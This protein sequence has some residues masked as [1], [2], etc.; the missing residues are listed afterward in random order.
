MKTSALEKVRAH[1]KEVQKN[2]K[3]FFSSIAFKEE[4]VYTSKKFNLEDFGLYPLNEYFEY[5]YYDDNTGIYHC[6]NAKGI[7]LE[8]EPMNGASDNNMEAI[9]GF[10]QRTL[11]EGAIMHCLLYASPHLGEVFDDYVAARK[12]SNPVTRKL[13]EKRA[14]YWKRG[15]FKSLVSWQQ[16]VLR[17]Y[18]LLICL[19]FDHELDIP[20]SK[21]INLYEQLRGLFRS[22]NVPNSLV[23]PARFM[24]WVDTL[25]RPNGSLYQPENSYHELNSLNSLSKLLAAPHHFK[26]VFSDHILIDD[27]EWQ[28]RNYRVQ[29][30][31]KESSHLCQMSG[32]IGNL[33]ESNAQIGCPFSLS[34]IVKICN[35]FEESRNANLLAWRALQRAE[36]IGKFSPKAIRDAQ[37]A[38]EIISEIEK[39]ERLV[40]V[41]FQISLYCK[42]EEAV[43]H[44]NSLFNVFQSTDFKWQIIKNFMLQPVMMLSH[45]PL[46]QNFQW[47]K[48]MEKLG[49][50]Y[51]LW[52]KNAAGMMPMVAEPKGMSS[53]KFMLSGRRGQVLFFDPF[54]SPRGNYNTCVAGV[55]GAGKS[56]TVQDMVGSLVGTGGKVF[57]ID[58]GRS[59]K[60]LC[61]ELDGQF[62]EF[63]YDTPICLNP[64]SS[65]REEKDSEEEFKAFMVPL[66]S[67]MI[68]P[69]DDLLPIEISF[70]SKAVNEVLKQ[71][72]RNGEIDDIIHWLLIQEDSRAQDIGQ[73]LFPFS[74]EG[75]YGKYFN[76]VGN[77]DFS[78]PM[79]VFE[80]EEISG[81]KRFQS[82]IFALLM[83]QIT[84][85][86]YLGG[87]KTQ[88]SLFIDEAWDMLKGG[89]GAGIIESV[90]R[91]ARKYKGS[92]NAITQGLEDFFASPAARAAYNNSYWKIMHM[93]N[94]ENVETLVEAKQLALNPFEKRLLCSVKTEHGVY[95][96]LVIKGGGQ[97]YICG[98]LF[99]DPYSR[100]LYSTQA[101]DFERVNEL[102]SQ[103]L[104]L[105]DA[106]EARAKE[107]FPNEI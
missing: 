80:L 36:S 69:N 57:I 53:K 48:D 90:A 41:S 98:R 91:R 42:T 76:G 35:V 21:I 55:S 73:M 2:L 38:R 39:S 24:Q 64:F 102:C 58:V 56:V 59:Y 78:N 85:K 31:G 52:A 104:S 63:N 34:F 10:L 28:I 8:A 100:V 61:Q 27:G 7:V 46:G 74:T 6:K 84:E 18:K 60:K 23:S 103:G 72:G 50:L 5:E 44:E 107:N 86:M 67:L 32:L 99:L 71:K 83:N 95:S 16:N 4:K 25:L 54:G 77:V 94:K 79:I 9:Y 96:E 26:R 12:D 14:E 93:Q 81:N 68:N 30:F 29:E 19:V 49:L 92:L 75:Q 51:K 3:G 33:F 37:E 13:A 87:R 47:L 82:V 11:P 15:V 20:E 97:E 66:L 89:Q 88:I 1:Y 70:L 105:E 62:I 17:D 106:I 101:V 65:I 40:L 43:E 22:L 45:L